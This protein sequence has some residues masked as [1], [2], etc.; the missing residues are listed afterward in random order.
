MT[1]TVLLCCKLM[2]I[3]EYEY[4]RHGMNQNTLSHGEF[5]DWV[6]LTVFQRP[7][8]KFPVRGCVSLWG[9]LASRGGT[10]QYCLVWLPLVAKTQ[11]GVDKPRHRLCRPGKNEI[12]DY[13]YLLSNHLSKANKTCP[14]TT[15]KNT[16]K[17]NDVTNR[18]K[19][20]LLKGLSQ[21]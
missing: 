18:W 7:N 13:G 12:L 5:N 1:P 3:R 10:S 21:R 14:N 6:V 4:Y 20:P 11:S 8:G 2:P 9:R 19:R 16:P 17:K 15:R